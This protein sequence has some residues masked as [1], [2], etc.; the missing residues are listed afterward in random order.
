[1]QYERE[2]VEKDSPVLSKAEQK[3]ELQ[4]L[5][6]QYYALDREDNIDGI[7]CRYRY[8]KAFVLLP[9]S[10]EEMRVVC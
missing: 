3:R 8:I 2:D 10:L 5:M 7:K 4:S 9:R 1:M 6:L